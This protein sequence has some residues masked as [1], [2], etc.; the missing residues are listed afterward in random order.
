MRVGNNS[1]HRNRCTHRDKWRHRQRREENGARK[2][3][4]P[5][6]SQAERC[7]VLAPFTDDRDHSFQAS[8]RKLVS[9]RHTPNG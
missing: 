2:T 6:D 8:R 1:A 7:H 5:A 9:E 3:C 4:Q